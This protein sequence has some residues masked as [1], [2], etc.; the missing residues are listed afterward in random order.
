[1]R[2][3]AALLLSVFC[4]SLCFAQESKEYSACTQKAITQRELTACAS[5]EAT[6]ADGERQAVYQE[7]LAKA[8]DANAADKVRAM[9]KAWSAYVDAFIDAVYPAENKQGEYGS[10]FPMEVRLVRATLIRQHIEQLKALL[11]P[12]QLRHQ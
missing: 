4:C 12:D 2:Q 1:M 6:R 5:E 11:R 7:L 3:L 10:M 9:E 8:V